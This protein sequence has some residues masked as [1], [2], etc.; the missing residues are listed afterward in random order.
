[1]YE[2][3]NIHFKPK[4]VNLKIKLIILKAQL[5]KSRNF[6]TYIISNDVWSDGLVNLTLVWKDLLYE[7]FIFWKYLLPSLRVNWFISMFTTPSVFDSKAIKSTNKWFHLK[8]MHMTLQKRHT[9]FLLLFKCSLITAV[10]LLCQ[11]NPSICFIDFNC[12][13][14]IQI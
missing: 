10:S 12:T 13:F 14:S 9:L 7:V 3:L 8:N 6:E 1:M 4:F 2:A 11:L 5:Q